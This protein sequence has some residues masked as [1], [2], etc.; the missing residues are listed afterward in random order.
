MIRQVQSMH[1]ISAIS[2][3]ARFSN[4]RWCVGDLCC[5]RR[6][7]ILLNFLPSPAALLSGSR[8]LALFCPYW[9]WVSTTDRFTVVRH[10]Q[11]LTTTAGLHDQSSIGCQLLDTIA[12]QKFRQRDESIRVPLDERSEV[13]VLW[14]IPVREIKFDLLL[15]C[16]QRFLVAESI[17]DDGV[18][19]LWEVP[20]V[21]EVDH[22]AGRYRD[23]PQ[24][25]A[26][27]T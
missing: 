7:R 27:P 25:L 10:D 13:T 19:R 14:K 8:F 9:E 23:A 22:M 11:Q 1:L 4:N 15:K 12:R 18:V 3:G 26:S 6:A 21:A 20:I 5:V 17:R 2:D 24:C 16:H